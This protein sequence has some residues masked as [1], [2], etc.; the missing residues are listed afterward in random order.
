LRVQNE[1]FVSAHHAQGAVVIAFYL[2][3]DRVMVCILLKGGAAVDFSFGNAIL[4]ALFVVSVVF[5]ILIT[6]WV[7]IRVFS[8]AIQGLEKRIAT[9]K[10]DA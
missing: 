7:L 4:S 6:L 8:V 5:F 9:K 10:T 2:P 1:V 3:I